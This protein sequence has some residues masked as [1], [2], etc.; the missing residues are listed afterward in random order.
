MKKFRI[1]TVFAASV[2][3][4]AGCNGGGNSSSSQSS[5]SSIPTS[6]SGQTENWPTDLLAGFCSQYKVTFQV[7]QA[8][9]T[10]WEYEY[11]EASDEGGRY[12]YFYLEREGKGEDAYKSKCEAAGFTIDDS[13]YDYYGY[14]ADKGSDDEY[15]MFYDGQDDVGKD[16]F[17]VEVI[18]PYLGGGGSTTGSSGSS[19][20]STTGSS[21]SYPEDYGESATWPAEKVAAFNSAF[22][23]SFETPAPAGSNWE[24]AYYADS[25]EYG[26]Y[27]VFE[28]YCEDAGTPGTDAIEDTYK[29][30]LTAAGFNID[31]SDYEA[32]GYYAD[33]GS[34]DEYIQFY[35]YE[36][37]FCLYIFGP[38]LGDTP[39]PGPVADETITFTSADK[40]KTSAQGVSFGSASTG[41]E[42]DRGLQWQTEG[43]PR[44]ISFSVSFAV[45]A[46][47]IDASANSDGASFTCSGSTVTLE[48]GAKHESVTFNVSFAANET[49]TIN[50]T[51][52]GKSLWI[53]SISLTKA[54]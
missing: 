36:G 51:G 7:P 1:L 9:G 44:T 29:S 5:S 35:S 6:G 26:T 46:I 11:G 15:I 25:D 20:G 45:S 18:G 12:G 53:K 8:D 31:D 39:T 32:S 52:S 4:L 27:G 3:L 22:H 17:C 19:S 43:H 37:Y 14:F 13:L 47:V 50:T 49:I 40:G 10:N 41:W 54:A 42:D 38:Y 23:V 21:T 30:V 34:D 24:Y 2:L 16:W 33:K 28:A 48:K